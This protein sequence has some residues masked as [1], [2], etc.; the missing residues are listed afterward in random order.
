MNY[1]D[2]MVYIEQLNKAG[3]ILG[4]ERIQELLKRLGNPQDKLSI[5]HVAGTNGKGSFGAFLG[6][7][8]ET[9]G[10]R[11]GR[12]ISPVIEGY[13]ERIQINGRWIEE[14]AVADILTK[15]KTV[16]EKMQA[17]GKEYPTVFEIETAMALM[18][19][20]D[21][22]ADYVILEV[23][24]GGRL[25]STNAAAHTMLSVI[26]SVSLDHTAVLGATLEEIAR[27]KAGI[28]KNHQ[29]V[30][31]YRQ[32]DCVMSAAAAIC[33]EKD[34]RLYATD[35]SQLKVTK[36]TLAGQQFHYK[37]FENL[38][39][40][41]A[42]TYQV[43]N[44]AAAVDAA[45]LLKKQGASIKETDIYE[46]LKNAKW[47]GRFEIVMDKPLIIV[48]GAHNPDGARRLGESIAAYLAGRKVI[49]VAGIFADKDYESILS[50]LAPFSDTVFTHTPPVNRGLLAERLAQS[51]KKYYK[52]V[53][54]CE[55][56]GTALET[57]VKTAGADGAVVSFGSLS[58][59]RDLKN[60][61]RNHQSVL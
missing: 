1:S 27:E 8:L 13:G 19:F 47:H 6:K 51:A 58:T 15:I 60:W 56:I 36:R 41:A 11:T 9:A 28:I 45:L 61:L 53:R 35:W 55:S 2:A 22:Q 42:G 17:E 44:A 37:T 5:I 23:G 4:L 31:I 25:D 48:D 39:I 49:Y 43:Y 50:E 12:Y 34:S 7:I 20:K 14:K 26:T 54:S 52:N 46:G 10:Y 33:N 16:C 21:E 32:D 24:L 38:M 40:T 57:A 3:S 29:D 18:Y 59:I 30:L